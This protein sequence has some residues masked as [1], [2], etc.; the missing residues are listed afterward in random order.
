[1]EFTLYLMQYLFH[2]SFAL[3][4]QPVMC[5][6]YYLI[7]TYCFC[8]HLFT[9]CVHNWELQKRVSF[10]PECVGFRPVCFLMGVGVTLYDSR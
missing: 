9:S 3:C 2:I 6:S 4:M 1:M 8:C 10:F 5:W 7:V